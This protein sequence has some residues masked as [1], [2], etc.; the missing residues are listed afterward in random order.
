MRPLLWLVRLLVYGLATY[1]VTHLL[2][3]ERGPFDVFDWLRAKAGIQEVATYWIGQQ[4]MTTERVAIGFWAEL[5]NCP[6]CLSVWL[7]AMATAALFLNCVACDVAATWLALAG[8]SL[9]LFGGE[10]VE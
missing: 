5:L 8:V 6:L 3:Y 7:A 1:R 9:I 10:K 4:K 2:C